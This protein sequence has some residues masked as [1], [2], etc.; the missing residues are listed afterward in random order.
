MPGKTI[1]NKNDWFV[2]VN[3]HAGSSKCSRDWP[4]I[5]KLLEEEN[6]NMKIVFTE[7][8]FHA[9]DLVKNAIEEEGFKKVLVVGGDGTLNEAVN[10]VFKQKKFKTR[11]IILGIITVGTGNDWGRMYEMPESYKKQVKLLR[12]GYTFLQDVGEVDYRY[13]IDEEKRYFINIA[14]MGYDALVAQKTNLMKQKGKGGALAY[15]INLVTGLFQYK[16]THLDIVADGEMIFSGNVFSM[17]IGIC[18]YNGGGMMQLPDAIPDDG[19][20]DITV[21]KK[22]TKFRI[23]S[24]IKNLFDGSFVKMP[25]VEQYTG[26]MITINSKPPQKL[27]LETD[28]ESLGHSPLD[29]KVIPKAVRLIVKKRFS[30][31]E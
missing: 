23:V 1:K 31:T 21:I 11:E 24:N 22:T 30:G 15:L 20:F 28:G 25:E 5:K 13:A 17:S 14:G 26:Q 6:F 12:K 29:F 27:Y 7:K 8:Q 10:G 18:K 16:N 9:I 2:V 19:L 3:P 4:K